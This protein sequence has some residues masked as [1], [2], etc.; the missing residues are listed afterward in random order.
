MSDQK[1]RG[2]ITAGK[3]EIK[4][5]NHYFIV[6]TI[7]L[8]WFFFSESTDLTIREFSLNLQLLN[9]PLKNYSIT[10]PVGLKWKI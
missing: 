4:L 2:K 9:P 6:S 7:E 10:K 3:N 8:V 5:S 1:Q